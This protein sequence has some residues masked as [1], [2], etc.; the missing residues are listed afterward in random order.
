MQPTEI[1]SDIKVT[2]MIR[3]ILKGDMET[4]NSMKLFLEHI[5]KNMLC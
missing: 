5:S 4:L 3:S 2:Y 1:S